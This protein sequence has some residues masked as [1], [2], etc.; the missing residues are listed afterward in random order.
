MLWCNFCG[1]FVPRIFQSHVGSAPISKFS[2]IFFLANQT[3]ASGIAFLRVSN[4]CLQTTYLWNRFLFR[5][6]LCPD[7]F[8]SS[9]EDQIAS[10]ENSTAIFGTF[11]HPSHTPIAKQKKWPSP[12]QKERP[13][14]I[15][16]TQMPLSSLDSM[17]SSNLLRPILEMDL[18]E[19]ESLRLRPNQL[20]LLQH[21]NRPVRCLTIGSR[22]HWTRTFFLGDLT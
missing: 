15:K 6:I 19:E 17:T 20:A 9:L 2:H 16:T 1:T 22:L 21:K 13:H 18:A 10:I 3:S 12:G 4:L 11:A 7:R 5:K 14:A 8:C